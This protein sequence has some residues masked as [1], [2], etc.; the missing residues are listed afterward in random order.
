MKECGILECGCNMDGHCAVEEMS[1]IKKYKCTIKNPSERV[2]VDAPELIPSVVKL[3]L[4]VK[5]SN[6]G[7]ETDGFM[8]VAKEGGEHKPVCCIQC[9]VDLAD[10]RT[11]ELAKK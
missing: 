8:Y 3:G 1:G 11:K 2:Q 6:C 4:V 9:G 7:K 10:P 5:C